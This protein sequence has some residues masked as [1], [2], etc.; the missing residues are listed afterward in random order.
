[1][2]AK[3]TALPMCPVTAVSTSPNKGVVTLAMIEGIASA[4]IAL[5]FCENF[6]AR[7]SLSFFTRQLFHHR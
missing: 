6:R 4:S 1:M 7:Q 3:Y 5:L 2:A